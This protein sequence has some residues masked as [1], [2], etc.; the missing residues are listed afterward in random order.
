M[1]HGSVDIDLRVT[2]GKLL[3]LD[4][5]AVRGTIFRECIDPWLHTK[6]VFYCLAPEDAIISGLRGLLRHSGRVIH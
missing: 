5:T 2:R 6:M 4:H 3:Y 1:E